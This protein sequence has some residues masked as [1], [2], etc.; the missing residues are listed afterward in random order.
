MSSRGALVVQGVVAPGFEPVRALYEREMRTMAEEHT[1]LCVYHR[2]ERVV[3][4]WAAP[5]DAAGF[6]GDSLVNIFSSGKS[7]ESIALAALV[8]RGQLDYAAPVAKYWP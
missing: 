8:G 1:Q 5:A 7:L 4:L 3:D 6:S 2:G